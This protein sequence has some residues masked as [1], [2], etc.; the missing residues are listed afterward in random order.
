MANSI[1][2]STA[3]PDYFVKIFPLG[4]SR[5]C[6]FTT[7]LPTVPAPPAR[8]GKSNQ[9][10]RGSAARPFRKRTNFDKPR[11]KC[12]TFSLCKR[13]GQPQRRNII[14]TRASSQLLRCGNDRMGIHSGPAPV[15]P[16]ACADVAPHFSRHSMWVCNVAPGDSNG[17]GCSGLASQAGAGGLATGKEPPRADR[18][19]DP[20]R[21]F[22]RGIHG[23][24]H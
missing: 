6:H 3:I 17:P 1:I 14:I 20:G 19:G 23:S 13:L 7:T 2:R 4:L 15:W 21:P 24:V 9:A 11:L 22:A 16:D 18:R 12:S 10:D 5:G 8:A